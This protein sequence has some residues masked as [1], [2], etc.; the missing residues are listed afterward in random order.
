MLVAASP[1][2]HFKMPAALRWSEDESQLTLGEQSRVF[3]RKNLNYIE[4]I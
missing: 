4:I 1:T 2:W 3:L